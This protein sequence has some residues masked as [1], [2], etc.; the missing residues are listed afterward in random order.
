MNKFEDSVRREY[1]DTTAQRLQKLMD[2]DN[3]R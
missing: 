2:E 1:D 3:E